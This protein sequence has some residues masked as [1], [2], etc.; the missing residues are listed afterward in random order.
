MA[1]A[2]AASV[3]AM[4]PAWL[5]N[6]P[7]LVSCLAA[8]RLA[9]SAAAAHLEKRRSCGVAFISVSGA[10]PLARSQRRGVKLAAQWRNVSINISYNQ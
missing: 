7:A 3:V 1:M 9:A 5:A 2:A 8:W 4:Q 6:Q 10:A